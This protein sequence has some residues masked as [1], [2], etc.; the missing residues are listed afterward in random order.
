VAND[1]IGPSNLIISVA[2]LHL[3][4]SYITKILKIFLMLFI[5][6]LKNFSFH[7]EHTHKK[8]NVPR[9]T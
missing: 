7:M 2:N 6:M 9:G 5:Y 8:N 4:F 3:P 1:G